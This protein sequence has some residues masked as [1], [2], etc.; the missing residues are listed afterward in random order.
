[1]IA[2][3]RAV[4]YALRA[5]PARN[6]AVQGPD[7]ILPPT[8]A[9]MILGTGRVDTCE[10]GASPGLKLFARFCA[11]QGIGVHMLDRPVAGAN[12][13]IELNLRAVR[14]VSD[15]TGAIFC[16]AI[17]TYQKKAVSSGWNRQ[18]IKSHL[19]RVGRRTRNCNRSLHRRT[20]QPELVA[21]A[22]LRNR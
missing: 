6:P 20:G 7:K 13:N 8:A 17:K 22:M 15:E 10:F 11:S 14:S 19:H 1:M 12:R 5:E 18:A 3:R 16:I 4:I 21:C 2:S 9:V